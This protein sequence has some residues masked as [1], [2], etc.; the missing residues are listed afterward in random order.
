[1]APVVPREAHGPLLEPGTIPYSFG[2]PLVESLSDSQVSTTRTMVCRHSAHEKQENDHYHSHCIPIRG[3]HRLWERHAKLHLSL[4]AFGQS[5]TG[6]WFV[7]Y[8]S[9]SPPLRNA[10]ILCKALFLIFLSLDFDQ[11]CHDDN[12]FSADPKTGHM[13]ICD[14]EKTNVPISLITYCICMMTTSG[15]VRL[16]RYEANKDIL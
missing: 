3:R 10:E 7:S 4:A 16:K 12:N 6:R 2:F 13:M 9:Q 14:A 11:I 5:K 1:M 15:L 8:T